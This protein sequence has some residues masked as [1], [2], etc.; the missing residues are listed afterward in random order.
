VLSVG[1]EAASYVTCT[2]VELLQGGE[3]VSSVPACDALP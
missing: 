1:V 3:A 2:A